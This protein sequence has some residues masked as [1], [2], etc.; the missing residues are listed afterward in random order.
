MESGLQDP[1]GL[2]IHAFFQNIFVHVTE[3]HERT[4][5][6]PVMGILRSLDN[7]ILIS[8]NQFLGS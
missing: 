3:S 2:E 4:V 1:I 8:C 6:N 5:T 7:A